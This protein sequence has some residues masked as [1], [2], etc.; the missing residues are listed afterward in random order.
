MTKTKHLQYLL[1]HNVDLSL[2]VL[3]PADCVVEAHLLISE[4]VLKVATLDLLLV[5][6]LLRGDHLLDL[7]LL[8]VELHVHLLAL[9]LKDKVAPIVKDKRKR[10]FTFSHAPIS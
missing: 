10:C 6:V 5:E 9:I 1:P 4:E 8:L 3:I 2:K 7:V